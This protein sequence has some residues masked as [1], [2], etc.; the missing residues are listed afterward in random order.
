MPYLIDTPTNPRSF[1]T[2]NPVIYMDARS[3]GWPVES[4]PYRDDYCK[5]VRDEERQRGEYERRDR[6]LK[7]IW[8]EE[9]ERRRSEAE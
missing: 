8:T 4:L 6:Q 7:E 5:S 2:N 3:W 1:L 9:L